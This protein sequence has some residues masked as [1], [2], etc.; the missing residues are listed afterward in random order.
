MKI[1]ARIDFQRT[2]CS[3]KP[4]ISFYCEDCHL[5][6]CG[7]CID[8]YFWQTNLDKTSLQ[9]SIEEF[10]QAIND[11]STEYLFRKAKT[12][13]RLFRALCH[14]DPKIISI[15]YHKGLKRAQ[16]IRGSCSAFFEFLM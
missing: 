9:S 15:E 8:G 5:L 6:Y 12:G 3:G 2:T 10:L 7:H 14:C 16:R 13:K 11:K 4:T 1:M